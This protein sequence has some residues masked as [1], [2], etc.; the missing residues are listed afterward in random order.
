MAALT[1][2]VLA[3]IVGAIPS[4]EYNS[5][6]NFPDPTGGDGAV[7]HLGPAYGRALLHH[8]YLAKRLKEDAGSGTMLMPF[9]PMASGM[10]GAW[11]FAYARD[12]AFP[13]RSGRM[14]S[15]QYAWYLDERLLPPGEKR[16]RVES[17]A[18]RVRPIGR[19]GWSPASD[20][21]ALHASS[22]ESQPYWLRLTCF[23]KGA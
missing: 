19:L 11:V 10:P 23:R 4:L 9:V 17:K 22:V 5:D 1:E 16:S 6:Y 18:T 15:H 14:M 12:P 13:E 2:L 21:P 7:Y 20:N 8:P 3:L